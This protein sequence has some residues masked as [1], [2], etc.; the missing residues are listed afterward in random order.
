LERLVPTELARPHR[1]A[2]M[3]YEYRRHGTLVLFAAFEVHTGRVFGRCYRRQRLREWLGFLPQ[4]IRRY[5]G[6]RVRIVLDNLKIHDH[7]AVHELLRHWRGR[8]T[9]HF[10]PKHA[11]WLNQVEIWFSILQ[12]RLMRR[13][14]F[15]SPADLARRVLLFIRAWNREAHP[16]RWTYTGRPLAA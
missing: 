3:E 7:P 14:S 2:R 1:A 15:L 8:V 10:T 9:L 4:L 5:P 16:F 11:S 13:G 6:R 12:R